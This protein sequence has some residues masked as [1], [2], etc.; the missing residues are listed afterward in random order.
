[1]TFE[2]FHTT[3]KPHLE[4]VNHFHNCGSTPNGIYNKLSAL[5]NAWAAYRQT[6]PKNLSCYACVVEL[7]NDIYYEVS[8][9]AKQ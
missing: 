9:S 4:L 8:R 1:M 5:N 6:K 7:L 2:E 3:V